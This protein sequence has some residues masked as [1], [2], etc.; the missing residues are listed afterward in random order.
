VSEIV[1]N[2]VPVGD[3]VIHV[4]EVGATLTRA[5]GT[6]TFLLPSSLSEPTPRCRRPNIGRRAPATLTTVG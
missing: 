4:A 2:S 6:T 3:A 1:H 5:T